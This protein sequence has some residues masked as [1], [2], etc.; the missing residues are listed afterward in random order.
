MSILLL[1]GIAIGGAIGSAVRYGAGLAS[2]G[3]VFPW[4]TFWANTVGTALLGAVAAATQAG[5][6]GGAWDLALGAGLAGGLTTFS[7][8]A[9]DAAGLWRRG[10][11]RMAASYLIATFAAGAAAAAVGWSVTSALGP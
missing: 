6:L 7:T 4:G 2:A 11:R 3:R 1:A 10:A 9:V 5:S 8:L